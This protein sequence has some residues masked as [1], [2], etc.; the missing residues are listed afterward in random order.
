MPR[1]APLTSRIEEQLA[2]AG[3]QVAVEFSEGALILSGVVDTEEARQAA[4][5]IATQIAPNLQV[6]N[7]IEVETLLPTD[8]DHFVS[9]EPSA[10]LLDSEDEIVASGGELEPDFERPVVTDPVEIVGPDSDGAD[11]IAQSGE[12][13][14]PPDDPVVT[15][16]AHG[17]TQVLGGFDSSSDDNEVDTSSDGR[18]GDEALADAVRRELREDAATTDLR[19]LVVVRNGV[20]HLRGQVEDLDDA[21]NAED[22]AS[23][24]PGVREVVEELEVVNV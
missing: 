18:V 2:E 22:V 19:I 14:T 24:V 15:T 11:D 23:R 13:Y 4:A 16:D 17:R 12:V 1:N 9:E 20:V 10:E 21:D 5:D 7:Q 8:I 3:L 6:D